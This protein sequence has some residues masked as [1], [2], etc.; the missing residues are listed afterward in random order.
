MLKSKLGLLIDGIL[1]IGLICLTVRVMQIIFV[2]TAPG[3]MFP[4]LLQLSVLFIF[5][6]LVYAR[7]IAHV[8]AY[9]KDSDN[10]KR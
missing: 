1:S 4:T 3:E 10:G 8:Y 5:C 6:V 9:I 2:L 7:L